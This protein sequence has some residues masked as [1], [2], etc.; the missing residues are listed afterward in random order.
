MLVMIKTLTKRN[1]ISHKYFTINE[2]NK[3]RGFTEKN[4]KVSEIAERAPVYHEI[5]KN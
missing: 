2:R 1:T 5:K 3:L 4:Y